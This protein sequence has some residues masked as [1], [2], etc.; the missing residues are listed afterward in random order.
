M[1]KLNKPHATIIGAGIIGISSAAF[2]Q[3][4]GFDVTVIDRVAPG[5]GCSFGNAGGVVV[6][7]VMP[8][9]H[10]GV[11]AKIPGWLL[12]PL[13]PLT[14]RWRHL[15]K[16][17]PWF[18]ALGRNAMPDRVKA[19][20]EARADLCLR[21]LGDH[22][23]L[24]QAAGA[25]DLLGKE[26]GL[27]LYETE[28]Q[29]LGDAHWRSE[30]ERFGYKCPDLSAGELSEMEPELTDRLYCGTYCG[31][32]YQV[33]NPYSIVKSLAEQVVRDG[34]EILEVDVV[35]VE[36]QDKQVT[37]IKLASSEDRPVDKLVIAAGAWSDQW[38]NKFGT[39]VL[40]EAERGY[41]LNMADPGVKVGRTITHAGFIGALA[42]I[43]DGLRI[44]G[45]DEFAGVDAPPNYKRADVLWQSAKKILPN[46][47][48]LT[49]DVSRW[50]GRRPGTPDSLPVIGPCPNMG[51]V[52]YAFGHGHMGLSWGPTTGRLVAQIMAGKPPNIDMTPFKADRF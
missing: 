4:E 17:L 3:R 8:T 48:P 10:V 7:S 40:L 1:V 20:T 27:R 46:L 44:A 14:I 31:G 16:A 45:T 23:S 26:D 21:S 38:A 30:K 35:D 13:G 32:W 18:L 36:L 41:H 15:P 49:E 37:R 2:L 42:P 9:V 43:D 24:L 12:D 29:Y 50:M 33:K 11:L 51:N 34:G 6:C 19:I 25:S 52:W 28:A 39:K 22:R 5:K 47:N